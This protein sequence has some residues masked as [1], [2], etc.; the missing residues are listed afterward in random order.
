MVAVNQ[1]LQGKVGH[2]KQVIELLK[3]SY[4]DNLARKPNLG[5]LD[6]VDWDRVTREPRLLAL[7][8]PI[9]ADLAKLSKTD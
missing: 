8:T 4:R 9:L 5:L 6:G 7:W 3:F 1:A 2:M